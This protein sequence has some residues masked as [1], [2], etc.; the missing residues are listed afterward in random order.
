M[1]DDITTNAPVPKQRSRW[2]SFR[3]R[4]LLVVVLLFQL[5]L[6]WFC[7]ARGRAARE[8]AAVTRLIYSVTGFSS[9]GANPH[10]GIQ[11]RLAELGLERPF[12]RITFVA[13]DRCIL[14][15]ALQELLG[16][17]DGVSSMA[18]TGCVIHEDAMVPNS[19][20]QLRELNLKGSEC[21]PRFIRSLAECNNLERLDLS[22]CLL[23]SETLKQIGKLKQV[24]HLYLSDCMFGFWKK[25]TIV[26][27]SVDMAFLQTMAKLE[28]LDVSHCNGSR[29]KLADLPS[30]LVSLTSWHTGMD[31]SRGLARRDRLKE[32][33]LA[34]STTSESDVRVLLAQCANVDSLFIG[35]AGCSSEEVT[36]LAREFPTVQFRFVSQ[37]GIH[38][39]E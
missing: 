23:S 4:T 17:L 39:G 21:P 9:R 14:D 28:R 36:Q 7:Y 1:M 18:L 3:L 34:D 2:R 32:I 12:Y 26:P 13:A 33:T 37:G 15:G 35:G 10:L 6:I 27:E 22:G 19:L 29:P 20:S 11:K 8:D 30:S 38:H 31:L 16:N 5:P 25:E 24:R